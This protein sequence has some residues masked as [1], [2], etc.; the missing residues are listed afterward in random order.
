MRLS[1][2][3]PLIGQMI[4]HRI[5]WLQ[6]CSFEPLCSAHN[7]K[8]HFHM[9]K[10]ILLLCWREV[11]DVGWTLKNTRQLL[12]LRKRKLL[13]STRE[14]ISSMA[15]CLVCY[16]YEQRQLW[17]GILMTKQIVAYFQ[18]IWMIFLGGECGC[19]SEWVNAVFVEV[20]V[21]THKKKKNTHTLVFCL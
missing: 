19:C 12:S 6:K 1:T 5:I 7:L 9:F 4:V 11:P 3:E 20:N 15:H 18:P 16:N 17:I 2:P 8:S 13:L 21:R 14:C 10:I